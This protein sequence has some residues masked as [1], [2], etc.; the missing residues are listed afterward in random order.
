MPMTPSS[1]S[2]T[3]RNSCSKARQ[4]DGSMNA[5]LALDP[6]LPFVAMRALLDRNYSLS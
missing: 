5:I 3:L 6:Y 2:V 4:E 1:E